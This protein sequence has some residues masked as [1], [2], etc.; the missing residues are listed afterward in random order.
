LAHRILL[1]QAARTIEG[2][3]GETILA[4]ALREGVAYPHG[5]QRGRCGSC[6]SRLLQGE[7]EMLA[8][9]PFALDAS[10]HQQ[11]LI[12]AC[13]A[14]P[15]SDVTVDWPDATGELPKRLPI[16]AVVVARHEIAPQIQRLVVRPARA[17]AFIPGQYV[18][19]TLSGGVTRS[20]SP[21]SQPMAQDIEFHVRV[22][23][24]G[25][26][27]GLI[28][29]LSLGDGVTLAGPFG[30]AFLRNETSRPILAIAAS[31]GQAPIKSIVD[32][33]V[34]SGEPRAVRVFAFARQ[35]S[36]LYLEGY[37]AE[38]A[39]RH[40]NIAYRSFATLVAQEGGTPQALIASCISELHD[41]TVHIAGPKGFVSSMSEM[42]RR[43][44]CEHI[45]ADAF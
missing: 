41:W 15:S 39:V 8:H 11:G 37:F 29:R 4:A 14:V 31:T 22:V 20:Y 27:S 6:K 10:E 28:A 35:V 33:L 25:Q 38:L 19:V 24:G 1:P 34:A 21:A 40:T 30:D 36:H 9:S 17:M 12:L 7:V 42:V 18:N 43:Q 45:L 26:A 5:C 32:R 2:L 13:R 44:G 23:D 3:P 16:D